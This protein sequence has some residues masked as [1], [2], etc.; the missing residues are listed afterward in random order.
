MAITSSVST[1]VLP[2]W[3]NFDGFFAGGL[4][5]G[6]DLALRFGGAFLAAAAALQFALLTIFVAEESDASGA[7][8][9]KLHEGNVR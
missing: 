7:V 6:D 1:L 5:L 9:N 3:V 8:G 4:M 2:L